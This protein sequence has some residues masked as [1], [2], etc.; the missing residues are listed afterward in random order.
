MNKENK[1]APIVLFAYKRPRHVLKTLESLM[2]CELASESVLYIYSDGPRENATDTEISQ[3]HEVRKIIREK[4][5]CKEVC[6]VEAE[7]NKGLAQS[8]IEGV[9]DI[10]SRFDK[11]IVIEDDLIFSPFFLRFMNDA[12][13]FYDRVEKVMH[14]TG[15]SF[16]LNEISSPFNKIKEDTYFLTYVCPTGWATWKDRWSYFENDANVLLEKLKNKPDFNM[17]DYNCGYGTEFYK[18]LQANAEKKLSSWAVKWHTVIYLMNGLA[19]FPTRSLIDNTGFDNSGENSGAGPLYYA[20]INTRKKPEV[21]SIP[22]EINKKA[23]FAFIKYYKNYFLV[24]RNQIPLLKIIYGKLIRQPYYGKL[25]K[26][27]YGRFQSIFVGKK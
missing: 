20:K 7:K 17:E 24:R 18:Q 2:A 12:L 27:I 6:I 1:L 4:E 19:L 8:I 10:V 23:L 5:W 25:I 16:P 14:I 11:V 15:H 9:T 21:V 22:I 26:Q 3:I 13:N